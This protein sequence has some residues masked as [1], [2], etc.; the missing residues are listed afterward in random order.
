[1]N[2]ISIRGTDRG[3]THHRRKL[4]NHIGKNDDNYNQ[5]HTGADYVIRNEGT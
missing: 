2:I 3:E 4:N 1:M 5:M